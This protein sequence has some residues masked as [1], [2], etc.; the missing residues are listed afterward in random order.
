[1]VGGVVMARS[2]GG[3]IIPWASSHKMRCR[4]SMALGE[5]AAECFASARVTI[6]TEPY[7]RAAL[8]RHRRGSKHDVGGWGGGR[9]ALKVPPC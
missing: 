9:P 4:G 7:G 1:M 2:N 5:Q 6:I 8:P 3:C